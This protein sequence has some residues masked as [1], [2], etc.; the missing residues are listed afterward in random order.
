MSIPPKQQTEI[1]EGPDHPLQFHPVDEE[2]RYRDLVLSDVIK[3]DVL[4]ILLLLGCH[5]STF[6]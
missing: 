1:V 6:R 5:P 2:Y 3:K 4:E